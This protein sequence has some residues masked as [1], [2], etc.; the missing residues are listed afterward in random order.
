MVWVV[1]IGTIT[2][3]MPDGMAGDMPLNITGIA[4]RTFYKY[5]DK[6]SICNIYDDECYC[7]ASV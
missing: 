5:F 6:H 3:G 7:P 2:G 1:M 4:F